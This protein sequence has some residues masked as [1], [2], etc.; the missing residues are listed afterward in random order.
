M[1]L[2]SWQGWKVTQAAALPYRILPGVA[3]WAGDAVDV[4]LVTSRDTGRWVLPKGYIEAGESGADAA[5]REAREEAGVSGEADRQEIGAYVYAK[6]GT[7]GDETPL[8]VAV[9]PLR[10][11]AL[12]DDWPERKQRDRRWFARAAAA[13]AVDEEDLK[14]LIAEFRG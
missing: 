7:N 13:D 3:N 5:M 9:Y 6:R 2:S 1:K 10:V 8:T 4:L 14:L 11:R 12:A